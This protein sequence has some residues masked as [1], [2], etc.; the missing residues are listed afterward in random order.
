MNFTENPIIKEDINNIISSI[1]DWSYFSGKTIL[2][3]GA[4]GFIP[5]YI[6]YSHVST[7]FYAVRTEPSVYKYSLIMVVLST[8]PEKPPFA[9]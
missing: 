3:T 8:V 6:I 5:S 2:V 9:L 1:D 4:N 7:S